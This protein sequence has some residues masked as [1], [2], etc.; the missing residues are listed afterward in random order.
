MSI[1]LDKE[2]R[3]QAI[4]SLQRYF[5]ENMESPIGNIS[6]GALLGFF[7]EEIGPCIYNQAVADAQQRLQARLDDLG[8]EVYEE[9][10]A[11]WQKFGK[12]N[13]KTL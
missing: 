7:L 10:F 13:K 2:E 1:E 8:F 5:K 3:Q 4:E 6:A 12:P 9:V 11:Y